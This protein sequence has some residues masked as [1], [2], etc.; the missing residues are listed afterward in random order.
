MKYIPKKKVTFK[1]GTHIF[2]YDLDKKYN[3]I[4][5]RHKKKKQNKKLREVEN[6]MK[7][8]GLLYQYEMLEFVKESSRYSRNINI[9]LLA[10]DLRMINKK[11]YL[12]IIH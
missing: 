12:H 8:K 5:K 3:Y 1:E 2:F 7:D 6:Y 10:K 9:T 4:A 11:E